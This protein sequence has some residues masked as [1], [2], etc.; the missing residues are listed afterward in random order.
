VVCPA[1]LK[2]QW[3]NEIHRFCRRDVQLISGPAA[4][5]AGHYASDCFF[6]ICNYEQVLKDILHIERNE[7]DLIILDEGQRIKNWEAKTSRV[8]KGLK[9]RF[10]LVLSG[11]PLENRLDELYSVV[12]F[13]DDRRLG[14]GFRF[15]NHH[16]IVD[17]KG[18]VLGYKH[19]DDL[20]D[21]LRPLLLRRTRDSVKLELPERTD[22]IVRIPPT[23]EQKALHDAHMQTV[24]GI[25]R[26]KFLTEMDLLRLRMA[27][28]MCR[29]SADSTVLVDKQK[30]GYS[31]KLERLG[32][33][34]DDLADEEGR[35][36]VLFSEWTTMLNLI[37]PLLSKRGLR[38]V[39]LDG[40]VP[41]NQRQ[42]LVH[43]FQTDPECRFFI[44]TNAGSVGLNL[45]AANTV[46]NVDLPWNPAVLEQ[47]IARAHRMGQ[48]RNV[49]VY[50]LVTEATLEE[51]LLTTLGA[52]RDL[53]LAALDAES[54]V[55]TVSMVSGAEELRSRLEVL[56]G[57]KPE[58][59]I[60]VSQKREEETLV[61]AG[62]PVDGASAE[63]AGRISNP[64][65][66]GDSAGRFGKPSYERGS[67]AAR[68]ERV[69]A[70]GGELLGAV[71]RFLGELV[72][73]GQPTPIDGAAGDASALGGVTPNQSISTQSIPTQSIVQG[74]RNRLDECVVEE[75]GRPRLT[76][77]LP[78]RSA[79]DHLAQA[80][81]RL[82]VAT[83]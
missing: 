28:L 49:Q 75:D 16:R 17:E 64:S 19:L 79:L 11:T 40:S 9:S 54:Q 37:E 72:Q 2:S 76:L 21:R 32:E 3:R 4:E 23:G 14:P 69:A 71:F 58:A 63:P 57:A 29:M 24:C 33:L 41:Q 70:A 7:W 15:F 25:V 36:V 67:P 74:I 43:E 47:R 60:D 42:E 46:I 45:Q 73:E 8:V 68:R 20:R 81:S 65:E 77:T 48:T 61:A 30:P 26:K 22:E 83:Q 13:I 27:L 18:K 78:D 80:L 34:L 31:T 5:R 12:Q 38:F 44:T 10:A 50:I 82:L 39:R 56:L 59:N 52:K 62:A 6:T 35:K 53:A 55:D 51:N 66:Q 1:S